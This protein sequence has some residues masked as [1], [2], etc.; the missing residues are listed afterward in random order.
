MIYYTLFLLLFPVHCLLYYVNFVSCGF[1]EK[2]RESTS[3]NKIKSDIFA[4]NGVVKDETNAKEEEQY[5][6]IIDDGHKLTAKDMDVENCNGERSQNFRFWFR[7]ASSYY[8]GVPF[9]RF[10]LYSISYGIFV[11]IVITLSAQYILRHN[12][13]YHTKYRHLIQWSVCHTLLS[14]FVLSMLL[15]DILSTIVIKKKPF[16]G[17]WRIFDL[18]LHICW[19]LY[20]ILYFTLS[21]LSQ[22]KNC[23]LDDE[24]ELAQN[25]DS[26][27]SHGTNSTLE[28]DSIVYPC[29][30]LE[31]PN[32]ICEV[33]FAIGRKR[34]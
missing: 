23:M 20:L 18:A 22:S 27:L 4:D 3:T 34:C 15:S 16:T 30:A 5:S 10:L 29:K 12:S 6:C 25:T 28:A 14:T 7:K 8:L 1:G 21:I 31:L 19:G 2:T 26:T 9:N 24:H 32:S 11:C 13:N 17:F 33:I